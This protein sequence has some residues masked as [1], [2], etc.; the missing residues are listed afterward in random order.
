[1]KKLISFLLAIL[2]VSIIAATGAI[3]QDEN[4]NA[5]AKATAECG[6]IVVLETAEATEPE[7][8]TILV[9][10]IKTPNQKDLVIDVSLQC[11]LYTQTLVKSKGG[12]KDTSTAVGTIT[13]QVL[14]DGEPAYPGEVVFSR[15][16]QQLSATLQGI[17]NDII[18]TVQ[19]DADGNV[20][21][22]TCVIDETTLEEEEIELILDT[23]D[24]HAFN[25]IIDDLASGV[26]T[27]EVQAKIEEDSSA[28]GGSAS[29]I[30]TIGKGSMSIDEVRF[31]KDDNIF[32]E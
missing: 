30:A 6:E 25:F 27:I 9:N 3:A 20:T 15:R 29:A 31:V 22:V 4:P 16:S 2:V 21:G 13:V 28:Q 23:M 1:M 10:T 18:C 8:T 7:F 26:H 5:S 24:A 17:I 32:M 12:I 11:G 19:Y 14:V